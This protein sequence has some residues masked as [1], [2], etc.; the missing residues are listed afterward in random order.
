MRRVVHDAEFEF[1]APAA[2]IT[3]EIAAEAQ[4]GWARIPHA[5]AAVL[6]TAVDNV[7]RNALLHGGDGAIEVAVSAT[8][9]DV[10]VTVR[11]HGPGVPPRDLERI[12]EPFYRV[13]TDAPRPE[14]YGVG[15]ALA[16]RA[17]ALH[18]GRIV[19][20]NADGGGLRVRIVLPRPR[21][22]RP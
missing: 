21:S 18:G 3:L 12:F 9:E 1:Q 4:G 19:A 16:Q 5:D 10:A 13:A 2:R 7:V 11:D 17:A 6:H 15:L 22:A 8:R 14:G 20:E